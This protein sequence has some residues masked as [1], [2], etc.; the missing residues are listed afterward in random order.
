M[1]STPVLLT[2]TAA[3]RIP[4]HTLAKRKGGHVGI[5]VHT[6]LHVAAPHALRA[7]AGTLSTCCPQGTRGPALLGTVVC[8]ELNPRETLRVLPMLVN[9]KDFTD[10]H[11][12]PLGCHE[13]NLEVH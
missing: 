6:L 11:C 12:D 4:L 3:H 10:M 13:I 1:T 8:W 9:G 7:A 2:G 5:G